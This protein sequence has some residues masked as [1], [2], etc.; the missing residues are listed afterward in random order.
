MREDKSGDMLS[1]ARHRRL[2]DPSGEFFRILPVNIFGSPILYVD[3]TRFMRHA[4]LKAL[5]RDL[6]EL[7]TKSPSDLSLSPTAWALT[8]SQ[9]TSYV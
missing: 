5:M 4:S 8:T 6:T 9:R 1:G 2:S 7:P 3:L